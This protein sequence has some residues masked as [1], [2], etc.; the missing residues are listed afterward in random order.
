MS[1][2]YIGDLPPNFNPN[3]NT[4]F[5]PPPIE[6]STY[7]VIK[8]EDLETMIEKKV[9]E[10]LDAKKKAGKGKSFTATKSGTRNVMAGPKSGKGKG[11]ST[12]GK[13]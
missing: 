10:M 7:L 6:Y 8:T 9:N 13:C 4:W 1:Y 12:K 11:G 5:T 2:N 3:W